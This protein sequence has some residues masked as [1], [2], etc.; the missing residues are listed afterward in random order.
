MCDLPGAAYVNEA[1]GPGLALAELGEAD[2]RGEAGVLAE[3]EALADA[4]ALAE[5]EGPAEDEAPALLPGPD[6]VPDGEKIAG[7]VEDGG[8]VQ[9]V[10]AATQTVKV[11]APTVVVAMLA[12][13]PTGIA[14]TFM[15]P[16]T[17]MNYL[18]AKG[19]LPATD[20][21]SHRARDCRIASSRWRLRG[22][23]CFPFPH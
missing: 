10:T 11:A 7:C 17:E 14:R 8:L 15:K 16:P 5:D 3:A 21:G 19:V 22:M 12:A 20:G 1:D 18:P 13:A 9:A 4:E 23:A 6:T 2:V